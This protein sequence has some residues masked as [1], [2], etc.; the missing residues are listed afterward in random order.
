MLASEKRARSI[1]RSTFKTSGFLR[2]ELNSLRLPYDCKKNWIYRNLGFG[3]LSVDS[4]DL[5]CISLVNPIKISSSL[6]RIVLN[7]PSFIHDSQRSRKLNRD[8]ENGDETKIGVDFCNIGN[9]T[10]VFCVRKGDNFLI[11]VRY[12]THRS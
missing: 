3:H 9:R 5:K 4:N 1:K 6:L 12:E 2:D 11:N 7:Y 8:R 10:F